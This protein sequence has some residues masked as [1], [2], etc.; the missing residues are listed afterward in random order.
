MGASSTAIWSFGSQ[1]VAIRL[2]WSNSGA[3]LLWI[4]IGAAGIAGAGA[5]SLVARF[6][7]DRMHWTFLGAMAAGILSVGSESTTP[8]L[9]ISGGILFGVAYIMLT[10]VYLVWG[11]SALPDRPATGLVIG[12]DHQAF[13]RP[14]YHRLRGYC[15]RLHRLC[16]RIGTG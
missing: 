6:G 16:R 7:I 10:G 3:G 14:A 8:A 13:N 9:T 2:G 4:A 15:V 11:V 5:G 12:A 1:L